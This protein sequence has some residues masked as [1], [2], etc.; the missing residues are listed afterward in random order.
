MEISERFIVTRHKRRIVSAHRVKF[1]PNW[2]LREP[3]H[4]K[5]VVWPEQLRF[6]WMAKWHLTPTGKILRKATPLKAV[7]PW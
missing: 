6:S 3:S 4:R 7:N 5:Y 1:A 2:I